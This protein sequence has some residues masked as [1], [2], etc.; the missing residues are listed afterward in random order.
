MLKYSERNT[1]GENE[2]PMSMPINKSVPIFSCPVCGCGLF[3]NGETVITALKCEK[4]HSFDLSAQGYVNLMPSDKARANSGDS[5]QM[6]AARSRFLNSGYYGCLKNALSQAVA[7]ALQCEKSA[8]NPLVV[9]AGCGEGYYTAAVADRLESENKQA[10]VAG[11]DISKRGIK[12]AAKRGSSAAFAAAGIFDMPFG[13]GRA[14]VV[15]SIFAPLCEGEFRRVLAPGGRLIVVSP[16]KNH[17]LG[18]KQAVYDKPYLN[19]KEPYCPE[20]FE[21]AGKTEVHDDITVH[22]ENIGDLFLMTPYFWNT[23]AE[24]AARLDGLQSLDTSIDFIITQLRRI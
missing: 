6:M 12:A 3:L 14:A 17:L 13:A 23:P 21:V 5:P 24:Q 16:G 18:L 8:D 7:D 20:G 2:T 10:R 9:D 15:M 22:G 4:G 1:N 11:I 19:D